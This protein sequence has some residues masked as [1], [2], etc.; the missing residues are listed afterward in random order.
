MQSNYEYRVIKWKTKPTKL[1]RKFSYCTQFQLAF[2]GRAS[3]NFVKLQ[4]FLF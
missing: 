3:L 1:R 2:E 4:T